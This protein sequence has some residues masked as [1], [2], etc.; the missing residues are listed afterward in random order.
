[1]S[2]WPLERILFALAGAVT[3]TSVLVPSRNAPTA[4]TSVLGFET[5]TKLS[6]SSVPLS[7]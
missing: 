4:V 3:L 5:E 1:M 2:A 7:S 6:R